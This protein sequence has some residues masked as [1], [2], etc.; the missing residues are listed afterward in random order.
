MGT[1]RV[2]T[3]YRELARLRQEQVKASPET[4]A[5]MLDAIL[6]CCGELGYGR[7]SVGRVHRRVGG[8]RSQFYRYFESK[9][10]CYLAAYETESARLCEMV[11]TAG[12]ASCIERLEAALGSLADFALRHPL[13]AR[14][15]VVEVHAAGGEALIR[16]QEVIARLSH[17]LDSAC[18]EPGSRYPPPPM[19]AE[20]MIGAAEQALSSAL[21]SN[22]PEEFADAVPGLAWLIH[23]A[24][25]GDEPLP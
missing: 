10:E 13:K 7:V 3:P 11:Q 18:R 1:K 22:R 25:R 17:A 6:A 20:F 14:G 21:I 4:R 2:K 15:L 16:R 12:G 24:Y 23:Q 8:Y 19:T 5:E 9:A